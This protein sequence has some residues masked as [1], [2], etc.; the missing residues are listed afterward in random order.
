MGKKLSKN[1][2]TNLRRNCIHKRLDNARK[3]VTNLTKTA[4]T[5]SNSISSRNDLTDNKITN[6]LTKV[7]KTLLQNN[8]E[9]VESKREHKEIPKERYL[10]PDKR[11]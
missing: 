9:I 7:S 8:L 4:S 3:S 6:K 10:S 1:L 2:S 5:K 11:Q